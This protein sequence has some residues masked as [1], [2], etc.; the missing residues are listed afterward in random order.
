MYFS[1]FMIHAF[2]STFNAHALKIPENPASLPGLWQLPVLFNQCNGFRPVVA[3][4]DM[5]TSALQE[6]G[7]FAVP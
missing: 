6:H 2:I 4:T 7:E 1:I 3:L 5:P